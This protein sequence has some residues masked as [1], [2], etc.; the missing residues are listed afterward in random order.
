M[1]VIL[2]LVGRRLAEF[3]DSLSYQTMA[4]WVKVRSY[5]K[6]TQS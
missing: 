2:T 5:L 4:H 1:L 3:S 6:K